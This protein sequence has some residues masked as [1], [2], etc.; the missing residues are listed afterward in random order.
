MTNADEAYAKIVQYLVD[1]TV[2]KYPHKT[3][4]EETELYYDLQMYGDEIFDMIVWLHKEF[5]LE[6]TGYMLRRAPPEPF[7]PPISTILSWCYRRLLRRPERRYESLKV[8]DVVDAVSAGK[9]PD[10]GE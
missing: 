1:Y 2:P 7:M 4:T 10:H 5:G 3:I 6:P 9:W 8:Q